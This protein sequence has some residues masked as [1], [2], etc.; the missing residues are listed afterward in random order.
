MPSL[1]EQYRGT[2]IGTIG[3]PFHLSKATGILPLLESLCIR[4][5]D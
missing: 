5:Y 2:T 4:A 3:Y 1:G